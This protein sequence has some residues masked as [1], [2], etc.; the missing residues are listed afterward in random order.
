MAMTPRARITA[1]GEH[2]SQRQWPAS[3][4]P[5]RHDRERPEANERRTPINHHPSNNYRHPPQ[6]VLRVNALL[7]TM[8]GRNQPLRLTPCEA[9]TRIARTTTG[10]SAEPPLPHSFSAASPSLLVRSA[11]SSEKRKLFLV[12]NPN[13][14]SGKTLRPLKTSSNTLTRQRE[15]IAALEFEYWLEIEN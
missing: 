6:P 8:P 3:P 2:R 1:N 4:T 5:A 7:K 11:R 15:N 10:S 13:P 12:T 9:T 14:L